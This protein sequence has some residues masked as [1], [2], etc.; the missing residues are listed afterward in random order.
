MQNFGGLL[1]YYILIHTLLYTHVY[2]VISILVSILLNFSVVLCSLCDIHLSIF[3]LS[4]ESEKLKLIIRYNVQ[5]RHTPAS[6]S[7]Y[8][9]RSTRTN[10][11]ASRA[12]NRFD[13]R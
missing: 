12:I 11:A 8:V 2:H 1:H 5:V 13:H 6:S 3:T 10:V 9:L 7:W 4:H